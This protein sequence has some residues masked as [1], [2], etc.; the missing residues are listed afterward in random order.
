MAECVGETSHDTAGIPGSERSEMVD[1]RSPAEPGH[2]NIYKQI[3]VK[4]AIIL[5]SSLQDDLSF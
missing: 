3:I 5:Q 4:I 2:K 1:D